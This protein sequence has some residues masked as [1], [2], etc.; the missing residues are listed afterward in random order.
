MD[1][2]QHTDAQ[3]FNLQ[4]RNFLQH[5]E[6][7]HHSMLASCY[8]LLQKP[9]RFQPFPELI[10]LEQEGDL[11]GVAMLLSGSSLALSQFSSLGGVDLLAQYLKQRC[12]WLSK[13][14]AP[15]KVASRF[16]TNW[17]NLAQ[18]S[19]HPELTVFAY[20]LNTLQPFTWA[21]GYLKP[22]TESEVPLISQWFTAFGAEALGELPSNSDAWAKAQIDHGHAFLWHDGQPMAMGCRVGKTENGFRISMIYTPPESRRRGYGKTLTAALTQRLLEAGQHHCW[23]YADKKNAL[24]NQ[25]YQAIGYELM[26]ESQ[27][28]QFITPTSDKPSR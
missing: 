13:L 19:A 26:G 1:I 24:T 6:A 20:Q 12:D 23:L 9:E 10:T 21:N 17:S 14:K 18:Q 15:T 16:V 7:L 2:L 25:M 11:V 3:S 5:N 28:Y 27:D 22:A 4:V 8:S